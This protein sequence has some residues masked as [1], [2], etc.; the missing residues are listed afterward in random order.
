MEETNGLNT[1]PVGNCQQWAARKSTL[2][3]ALPSQYM[4]SI[5]KNTAVNF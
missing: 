1:Q 5:K 4:Q 3:Q 2:L